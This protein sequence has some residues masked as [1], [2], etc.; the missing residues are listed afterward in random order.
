MDFITKPFQA[1]EVLARVG[2]HLALRRLHAQL[3]QQNTQLQQEI[4]ERKRAEA[5]LRRSEN[6]YRT[7]FENTGTALT[8]I[9]ADTVISFANT[10]FTW[11]LPLSAMKDR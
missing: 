4:E 6:T 1:E 10:R 9:E 11:S 8:I 2:A 5:A 7:I 3:E